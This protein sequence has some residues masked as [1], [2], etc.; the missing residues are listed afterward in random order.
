MDM[1]DLW[2]KE[3]ERQEITGH[4]MIQEIKCTDSK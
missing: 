2:E 4:L 1:R 3:K